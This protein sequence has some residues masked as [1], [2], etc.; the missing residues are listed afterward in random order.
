MLGQRHSLGYEIDGA[1]VKIDDLLQ[2]VELGFTSK[3]PRWAIA[4]NSRP[5]R[6]PRSCAT[7][8]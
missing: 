5:R 4:Y 7:S 1:V 3:A 6:R 2:R 8:W